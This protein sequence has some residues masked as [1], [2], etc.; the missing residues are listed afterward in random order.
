[1]HIFLCIVV[2]NVIVFSPQTEP[3]PCNMEQ[4]TRYNAKNNQTEFE[5]AEIIE[6]K[7]AEGKEDKEDKEEKEEKEEAVG[8]PG[9]S[10]CINSWY[11]STALASMESCLQDDNCTRPINRGH[12]DNFVCQQSLLNFGEKNAMN[13]FLQT[14][15]RFHNYLRFF[16]PAEPKLLFI[17]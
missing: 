11:E 8:P 9:R 2:Y 13:S 7:I 16:T 10:P 14:D 6:Q 5:M 12:I 3:N 15:L 17:F 1:M 4:F